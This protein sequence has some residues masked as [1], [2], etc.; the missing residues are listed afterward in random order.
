MTII[1]LEPE[2]HDCGYA[3]QRGSRRFPQRL[4][5]LLRQV[6]KTKGF[7]KSSNPLVCSLHR[8]LLHDFSGVV[9]LRTFAVVFRPP[10]LVIDIYGSQFEGDV[11]LGILGM[12]VALVIVML[13]FQCAVGKNRKNNKGN[14]TFG[15][16]ETVD[17]VIGFA[18]QQG[19]GK[20]PERHS[21]RILFLFGYFFGLLCFANFSANIVT[22]LTTSKSLESIQDLIDYTPIKVKLSVQV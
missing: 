12:G 5:P 14:S 18:T 2:W 17:W 1:L 22:M 4:G 8:Y 7:S 21:L 16:R 15:A 6:S 10:E 13:A 9:D 11:W 19:C 3:R 20:V